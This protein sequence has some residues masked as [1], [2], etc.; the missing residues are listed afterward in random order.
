MQLSLLILVSIKMS[1]LTIKHSLYI[2]IS[3]LK[4]LGLLGLLHLLQNCLFTF[5]ETFPNI[6]LPR[7]EVS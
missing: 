6:L 3:I 1:I 5:S 7:Y 4:V 2:I